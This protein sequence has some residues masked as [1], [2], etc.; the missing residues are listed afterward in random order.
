MTSG[1]TSAPLRFSVV[2]ASRQRP[3]WLD[4]CLRALRQ[5]DYPTFEIVVVADQASLDR[6][7]RAGLKVVPFAKANLSAARNAGIAASAGD[8]CAFIDD[9]AVPEPMWLHHLD[10]AFRQNGAVAVTGYVRGRNGINFQSRVASVDTEAETHTETPET[11]S[12]IPVLP[13]GRALKLVGTNMAIRRDVFASLGGFDELYRYFLEDTDLSLRIANA[14][15][16]MAVAP[17]AEVHHAFAPSLRRT[18]L[19]TPTDLF[20]IGRSSAV[21]LRRHL[22]RDLDEMYTRIQI[23]ERARLLQHMQIGSCEPRDVGRRLE[24][25]KSGWADG[26]NTALTDPTA[27]PTDQG[28]E[29]HPIKHQTSGHQVLCSPMYLRRRKALIQAERFAE[30]GQRVSLFSLSLTPVRHHLRYTPTGV[31]L[32]TGGIFGRS[33]RN[34]SIFKWCRFANRCNEEIARVANQR[35]IRKDGLVKG[36]G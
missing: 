30:S 10:I 24:G 18:K 12:C 16:P 34:H 22:G 35:G 4:R 1:A 36:L 15:L 8:V 29:Y 26:I 23:R 2:V 32:Q 6:I 13:S 33:I 17:L 20:D 14:G 21:F 5:L 7:G 19:R 27:L 9:D 11:R 31:W 25:L 28:T 3:S